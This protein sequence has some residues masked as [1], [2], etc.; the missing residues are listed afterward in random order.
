MSWTSWTGF[1]GQSWRS[2]WLHS[3]ELCEC[4]VSLVIRRILVKLATNIHHASSK[5]WKGQRSKCKLIGLFFITFLTCK[6]FLVSLDRQLS[7]TLRDTTFVWNRITVSFVQT[8]RIYGLHFTYL[9]DAIPVK[10]QN[11]SCV[12]C[13]TEEKVKNGLFLWLTVR[14]MHELALQYM[15]WWRQTEGVG[16]R[17]WL[18]TKFNPNSS[19]NRF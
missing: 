5:N 2:R 13:L 12:P 4:D 3:W 17:L 6:I 11:Y 18:Q 16:F 8:R 10:C 1:Q 19:W 14:Q 9:P 15:Q 7:L